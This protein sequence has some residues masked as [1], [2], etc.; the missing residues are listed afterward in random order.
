MQNKIQEKSFNMQ[1]KCIL[2]KKVANQPSQASRTCKCLIHRGLREVF[3]LHGD[4][5]S[6]T[7]P[8]MEDVKLVKAGEC[9]QGSHQKAINLSVVY[10]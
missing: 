9:T 7:R 5:T 1:N 2:S 10:P 6:F 8:N 3:G 4:F